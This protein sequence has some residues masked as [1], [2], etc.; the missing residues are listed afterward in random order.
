MGR[1]SEHKNVISFGGTGSKG[2]SM[3]PFMSD[4]LINYLHN[5]GEL[6]PEADICRVKNNVNLKD[7]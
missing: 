4:L 1:H 5:K 3:A 7:K 6:P 2:V